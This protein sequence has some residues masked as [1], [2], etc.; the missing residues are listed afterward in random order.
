VPHI[1]RP[2]YPFV[3]LAKGFFLR[4][5]GWQAGN[6]AAISD[7]SGPAGSLGS[8]KSTVNGPSNDAKSGE[9]QIEPTATADRR[10]MSA[11]A[12]WQQSHFTK[13]FRRI[14]GVTPMRF[15]GE[16]GCGHSHA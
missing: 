5:P 12:C 4:N 6:Q 10:S 13:V 14:V 15:R 1:E 3:T 8:R 16:I 9:Y 2:S 11:L 7:F